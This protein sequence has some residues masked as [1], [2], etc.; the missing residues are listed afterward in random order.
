MDEHIYLT[1]AEVI[2]MHTRL[3]EEFGGAK[4]IRDAGSLDAAVFRPQVGYYNS[5]VE[6]AA[7]LM[8]SLA[9][10]HAFVDGNKRI[11]FAATDTFLRING[12]S[13]EVEPLTAHHFIS[14]S[15]G[16]ST[17]RFSR[18][19]DWIDANLKTLSE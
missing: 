13:L 4:G 3:I 17:F 11:C 14:E 10:N 15:L 6:E 16:S 18:I 19:R 7:A 12:Y 2:E 8:E 1:V 9:N 5:S